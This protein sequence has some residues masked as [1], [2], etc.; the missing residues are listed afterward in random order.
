MQVKQFIIPYTSR[1]EKIKIYPLGDIHAGTVHCAEE[2]FRSKVREVKDNPLAYWL[3]MGDYSDY[4]TPKDPRWEPSLLAIPEWVEQDNIAECQ[5]KRIVQL[6]SPIK[7]KCIGLLYGNHEESIRRHNHANVHKNICD[8]LGVDN[9]GYSCFI[10]FIFKRKGLLGQRHES[11]LLKGYFTHG[12]GGA[13]T[14]GAKLNYL[15]RVMQ[16]FEADIYGYAHVHSMQTH[17]PDFLGSTDQ[18]LMIKAKPKAGALTGCWFRTYTQGVI[19]SYGEMKVY[20]PSKIGCPVFVIEP[21]K[22]EAKV[23]G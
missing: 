12:T 10:H 3:G 16:S 2:E 4:I 21:N 9:L 15:V 8:D 23:E 5:R 11:W 6:L 20:S 14:E 1:S 18:S 22:R 13:R 7:G 17:S 19:A